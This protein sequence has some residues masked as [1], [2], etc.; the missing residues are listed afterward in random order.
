MKSEEKN[1]LIKK[2][3]M[4]KM[5]G[6]L[7][8]LLGFLLF[9][10]FLYTAFRSNFNLGI[11][12]LFC[13]AVFL[14][15]YGFFFHRLIKIKW[16]TITIF[17]L[18][19]AFVALVLFLFIY[20]KSDNVTYQEEASTSTHENL[21]FAKNILDS[22]FSHPYTTVVITNDFHIYRAAQMAKKVGLDA[23]HYHAHID[24]YSIPQNYLRES[25]A[26]VKYWVTR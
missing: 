26:V 24:W 6:T 15:V 16:L 22:L 5:V 23:T 11:V 12:F 18:A 10:G 21:L 20:G 7:L 3:R 9:G 25:A 4:V 1:V 17:T 8:F 13:L 2:S 14:I 19:S